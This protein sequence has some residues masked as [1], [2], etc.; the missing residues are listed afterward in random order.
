[1][2]PI[3]LVELRKSL[4]MNDSSPL[5]ALLSHLDNFFFGKKIQLSE[6]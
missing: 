3:H 2:E 4:E 1:M 6:I 5:L